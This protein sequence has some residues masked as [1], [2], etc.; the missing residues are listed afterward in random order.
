[1]KVYQLEFTQRMPI[2]LD[3]AWQFF[4]SPLNLA[5]ITP[6]EMGFKVTSHNSYS[7]VM[8]AGMVITYKVSPLYGINLDWTT[9]ITHV[10]EGK[11]FVDEQRFG[12][13]QFWH[14]E[15][16]FKE[17]PGGVEM[18]DI[19]SYGMPFGVIGRGVN[20]LLVAKKVKS[21][22]D[23]RQEKV[24]ALFGDYTRAGR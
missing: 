15:H 20:R 18:H 12:P 19:L 17:I 14:H 21:I 1:M 5:K 6:K 10:S 7:A 24:I 13:Y 3:A 2:S 8:Y 4:S 22:F 11:Y 16:H 9:E 23:Y